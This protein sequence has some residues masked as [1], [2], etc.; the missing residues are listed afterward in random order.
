MV[1]SVKTLSGRCWQDED[2]DLVEESLALGAW[3]NAAGKGDWTH[4]QRR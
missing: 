3:D 1:T 4:L 2:V